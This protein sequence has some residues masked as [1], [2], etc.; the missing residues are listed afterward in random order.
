MTLSEPAGSVSRASAPVAPESGVPLPV[1]P[2]IEVSVAVLCLVIMAQL[3]RLVTG[4]LDATGAS[5]SFGDV[6]G[7]GRVAA[8]WRGDSAWGAWE[9][10]GR[11]T[12]SV[13]GSRADFVT[14]LLHLHLL[15]DLV[16]IA[17]YTTLGIRLLHSSTWAVRAVQGLAVVDLAEN[18]CAFVI[19]L[20]IRS[21]TAAP[22]PWEQLVGAFTA[23]KWLLVAVVVVGAV[24]IGTGRADVVR[25]QFVDD[26][27]VDP[28]RGP[29]RAAGPAATAGGPLRTV[30]L[31]LWLQRFSLLALLP[32]AVLATGPGGETL[33][34][35]PDVARSWA[36]GGRGP[37]HFA[38]ACA[39]LVLLVAALFVLGRLRSDRVWRERA[40]TL[41]P[42]RSPAP[43]LWVATAAAVVV[44]AAVA[45]LAGATVN[46]RPSVVVALIT[47][48]VLA[49]SWVAGRSPRGHRIPG[50]R[51]D[52]ELA[53]ATVVTGDVLSLV[54]VV[55]AG[56]G[57]ARA[58]A[59]PLA[60]GGSVAGWLFGGLGVVAAVGVW[61]L[62][63]ALR[64]RLARRPGRRSPRVSR[65]LWEVFTPGRGLDTPTAAARGMVTV[66]RFRR[67]VRLALVALA[68]ALLLGLGAIPVPAAHV[69]GVLAC[70]ELAVTALVL[71][72]G[73]LVVVSRDHL[74]LPLF[75]WLGL[76]TTPL[77]GLLLVGALAVSYQS[78]DSTL[79]G[80]RGLG[81]VAVTSPQSRPTLAEAFSQWVSRSAACD[82]TVPTLAGAPQI[83]IRPMLLVAADGGGIRAAHWTA[84][85]MTAIRSQGG[86]CGAHATLM[87]SGVSGGSLGLVLSQNAAQPVSTV[88]RLS[89]Q[90]ALAAA[91]LGLLVRDDVAALT[92]VYLPSLFADEL[93]RNSGKGWQDRAALMEGIWQR[94][95][96]ELT[97]SFLAPPA[98]AV[99]GPLILNS[100]SVGMACR[101]VV[102]QV[103]FPASRL[104]SSVSSSVSS[105]STSTSASVSASV[106]ASASV[107]HDPT[108]RTGATALPA[109]FDLLAD[110]GS[111]AGQARSQCLGDLSGAAAVMLSA[112][113]AYVTPSGVVGPCGNL[114]SQ[115]LIDGGYAEGS[116]LGTL[117][118]LAG[119]GSPRPGAAVPGVSVGDGEADGGADGWVSLVRRH[120]ERAMAQVLGQPAGRSAAAPAVFLAP[121]I[122]FLQNHFRSDIAASTSTP[123][124][125]LLVPSAGLA[126]RAAQRDTPA[127]LQ[128]ALAATTV[129]LPCTVAPAEASSLSAPSASSV[130]SSAAPS[131]SSLPA[132]DPA[133]RCAAVRSAVRQRV[134][135]SVV[136]VSPD[137]RPA[138]TAPLGWVLSETSRKGLDRG[139]DGQ[140]SRTCT[141]MSTAP[142]YRQSPDCQ[143]GYGRLADLLATLRNTSAG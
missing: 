52:R 48:L 28:G 71:L 80:V 2:A 88:R 112:R 24:L 58:Y 6:F 100:T 91:G 137:T 35:L 77:A 127:L 131:V 25:Q 122:V 46:W 118:D 83:R 51:P 85:A 49:V 117:I 119:A 105:T 96:P 132:A 15:V 67:G 138:V 26:Q 13:L 41:R 17:V 54:T 56:V 8:L 5:W 128:R 115:Q 97:R 1:R 84:S 140:A 89:E 42:L 92:G 87:S 30:L 34:Q 135:Y 121:V 130:P 141:E 108:C 53:R 66:V 99:T 139:M 31:A 116:G 21:G 125:E 60:T 114:T 19:G 22:G 107:P 106:S 33:D 29:Q 62:G 43:A 76:R 101:A 98:D 75:R 123:S 70:T 61:P 36:D 64:A 47:M 4:V 73:A 103:R 68:I 3:N 94:Q 120:N 65:W 23:A 69:L 44:S 102:S 40:S 11:T 142:P 37:A 95:A 7:P 63:E 50:Y 111:P 45:R 134:P 16:F 93:S 39:G 18:G 86:D 14:H 27:F 109:T 78:G 32:L 126:A 136:V 55:V 74:P 57:L 110:Y 90:D 82:L 124:N 20:R 133:R 104:S 143:A 129:D 10:L 72:V 59:A 9:A 12:A 79:H 81:G 38:W 113:F